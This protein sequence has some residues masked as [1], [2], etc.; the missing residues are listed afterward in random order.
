MFVCLTCMCSII[1][2]IVKN[3]SRVV[4]MSAN[5]YFFFYISVASQHMLSTASIQYDICILT[6]KIPRAKIL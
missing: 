4:P 2:L 1:H 5:F 3:L 6:I